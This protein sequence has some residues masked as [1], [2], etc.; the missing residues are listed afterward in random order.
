MKTMMRTT[1]AALTAL[2]LAGC[3]GNRAGAGAAPGEGASG[4]F[5]RV[6]V[7]NDGTIPTQIR[8]YLV[9][10]TGQ[11]AM[12]G[13][14]STLG[15]ETLSTTLPMIE[16]SYRLRAEGGTG[17]SLVSPRVSLRGNETISWDLR[18]NIVRLG[19]R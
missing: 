14:M 4:E 12:L 1:V 19:T 2:V 13:S 18:Q 9:P 10:G 8:V 11:E 16:G 6:Q 7:L 15:T 3:A 17:Y 5:L